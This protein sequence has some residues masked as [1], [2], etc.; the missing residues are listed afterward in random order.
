MY[1]RFGAGVLILVAL[2]GLVLAG[3]RL[4][5]SSRATNVVPTRPA[6][7]GSASAS[8]TKVATTTAQNIS[9]THAV[10]T[11]LPTLP[12][13]PTIATKDDL[14]R[15][16]NPL[17]GTQPGAADFGTGGGAG[18]V[19]PGA[20]VPFGMVQWSPDTNPTQ[21]GGYL[22]DARKITGFSLTHLSGAG[23]PAYG[24]FPFMP[25]TG[26]LTTS[27]GIGWSRYASSFSHNRESASP[28][29]YSVNLSRSHI[30]AELTATQRSGFARFT[31][32]RSSSAGTVLID[33]DS[34]GTGATDQTIR[35][36]GD[37]LVMGTLTSGHF[38]NSPGT[39]TVHFAA[40][41]SRPFASTGVW[42]NDQ[43]YPTLKKIYGQKSGA[44]LGF[45]T[46]ASSTVEVKVGLSFVSEAN[47][48]RN[49]DTENPGWDFEATRLRA[50]AAWDQ[51]LGK[52]RVSG[53]T[54]SQKRIF[55][56]ALYHVLLQPNVFSDVNGQYIGFDNQVHTASGYTQYANFSG[57]DIY[58]SE[59]Q[60][61]ALL[62]PRE[63]SDMMQ[64]L[65]ADAREG[66]WLPKWGFANDY[67]GVMVGDP[68]DPIIAS[69]YAFG[70]RHFDTKPA[71][72]YMVK[73]ASG[74][75][76]G[77]DWYVE[78]PGLDR[79]LKLGY[80]PEGTDGV[81][82]SAATTLEYTTADFSI[83]Q[84]ARALGDDATYNEF[85]GRSQN[86]QKLFDPSIG[87]IRP[88]DTDGA[89][90]PAFEPG[91]MTGFVEG[92]G[93]QYTWMVPYNVRS[94]FL[95]MGGNEHAVKRL[96]SFFAQLNA[97]TQK[98]Y[99]FMGNE[100]GYEVPWEYNYAGQ[101]WRTQEVVHRITRTLYK[102]GADGLVGNDDLGAESSWYIWTA[103]GL[104]PEVPGSSELL[105]SSPLFS[106]VHMSLGNGKRLLIRAP[107][108]SDSNIYVRSLSLNG[109]RYTK[110]WLPPSFVREGGVLNFQLSDK[111]NK[112]WG[113]ATGDIPTSYGQGQ[114]PLVAFT[115]PGDQVVVNPGS[116]GT[117][118]IGAVNLSNQA[119]TVTWSTDSPHGITLDRSS[120]VVNVPAGSTR[121]QQ[122]NVRASRHEGIYTLWVRF[123]TSGAG[124]L[125][126]AKFRVVVAAPGSLVP[127]FN[128]SGISNDSAP[129][130]ANYDGAGYS[131]SSEALTSAGVTPGDVIQ[132]RGI[133][134]RW[135]D[136][137]E[138]QPD[139]VLASGQRIAL[140][141][142]RVG[143]TRLG[144]L[145]SAT[146]GPSAGEIT[147]TYTDGTKRTSK[148]V[149]S[150]WTLGGGGGDV[151]TG[152]QIALKTPYRNCSC[153]TRDNVPTYVFFASVPL[154]P[155]KQ[156]RSVTLP[157]QVDQGEIHIFAIGT[158]R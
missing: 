67:T 85:S 148:L 134:F 54:E 98:P 8:P 29:Y 130:S 13:P 51:Q 106:Q 75:G 129:S 93:A 63:T 55:Y 88:R 81:W 7:R 42:L 90:I 25:I 103:M 92:N 120:G 137:Q 11:S 97:G 14:A 94:L 116:R 141:S 24:D 149:M 125:P 12:P 61:L 38:C 122:V 124:T 108:A 72:K 76:Q 114:R 6:S 18:N 70:A 146:N 10:P 68:A 139:N 47:A 95:E 27:P 83:A 115:S 126:S 113:T 39:Y 16:V 135:P 37:D 87:Y 99:S 31:F 3:M 57:W 4:R 109:K 143:D 9:I 80:V 62:V 117:F 100:P 155:G 46:S 140:P 128:N 111:V 19:F 5:D 77:Q 91:S 121:Y 123:D 73:G 151:S 40:R 147:V 32:P 22:Y 69:A 158:G 132:Y 86:W 50:R 107:Q 133:K 131:Y 154:D 65:V 23:C 136:V 71:L 58:R 112:S 153:G 96:D 144:L 28:G 102:P 64:S 66:G 49:L 60:L 118:R 33:S 17:T 20:D 138:R 48:L 15:Y 110:S 145:G 35:I 45:D 105:M 43:L 156:V 79:Y 44:Y 78:R 36:V 1:K 127:Y 21:P 89:F 26:K 53:G 59:I 104:Y 2:I 56:T 157:S 74:T 52:I 84:F 41:F 82:G 101:P 119:R 150:D 142:A 34:S 30:R 152:N